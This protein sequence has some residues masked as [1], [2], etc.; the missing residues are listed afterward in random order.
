LGLQAGYAVDW[1][2]ITQSQMIAACRKDF[3]TGDCSTLAALIRRVL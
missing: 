2:R 3:A 1:S